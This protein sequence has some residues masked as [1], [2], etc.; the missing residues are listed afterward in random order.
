MGYIFEAFPKIAR[1][2]RELVITEKLD[3]TNAQVAFF[4]LDTEDDLAAAHGDPYCMDIFPGAESG[5]SA[6][7]MYV[8]SR[9]RWIAPEGTEG[10]DK[11]C[12][13]FGFAR[14]ALENRAE[15]AK[16]GEGRHYGEW[17]GEGIQRGYGIQGKRFALFNCNRWGPHNPSTPACCEVVERLNVGLLEKAT[18]GDCMNFLDTFG[19]Q[20]VPGFPKPEGIV[21]YHTASRTYYKQ[22]FEMD[23]GKGA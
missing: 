12:D 16:L 20:H 15:L 22:T 17:Y 23:G 18:V 4:S 1:Y 9:Q 13:N 6:L 2:E 21:I 8:G 19:S 11:G 14:W 3:G 5:D 10:L 7:A